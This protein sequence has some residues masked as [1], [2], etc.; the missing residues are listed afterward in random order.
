MLHIRLY[1]YYLL[2][3]LNIIFEG[4]FFQNRPNIFLIST[5]T[6]EKTS[7]FNSGTTILSLNCMQLNIHYILPKSTLLTLADST[8]KVIK[9]CQCKFKLFRNLYYVKNC[10]L[11]IFKMFKTKKDSKRKRAL[12]NSIY[13]IRVSCSFVS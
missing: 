9:Y 3:V 7:S 2:V 8:A 5:F 13:R 4:N 12:T 10:I 1:D 11:L 6:D